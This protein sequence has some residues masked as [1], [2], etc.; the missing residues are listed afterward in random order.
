MRISAES[1]DVNECSL[2]GTIPSE[3]GKLTALK[4]LN[5]AGNN[6]VGTIPSQLNSFLLLRDLD[7]SS[8]FL[9]GTIPILDAL[10]RLESLDLSANQLGGTIPPGLGILTRNAPPSG[11]SVLISLQFLFFC[12]TTP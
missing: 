8:N 3:I 12:L 11:S 6:I 10:K 9:T 4:W 1:L 2:E 7:L 5:L